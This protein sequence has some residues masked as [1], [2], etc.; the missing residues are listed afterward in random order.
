MEYFSL[1]SIPSNKIAVA[2][3]LM[4]LGNLSAALTQTGERTNTSTTIKKPTALLL[5]YLRDIIASS[6]E[7]LGRSRR[8][9]GES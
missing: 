6:G 7:Y 4:F 9:A 1:L 3:H 2:F 5:K 8:A